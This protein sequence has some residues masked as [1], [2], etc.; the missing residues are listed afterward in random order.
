[1][2]D[3][4]F[5][6]RFI[7][8]FEKTYCKVQHD[9]YHIY[10]VDI[11]SLFAVGEIARLWRGEHAKDLPLL[12]KLANDVDKRELLILAVLLHDVGKGEGGGHADKGADLVPTNSRRMGLTKEDSERLEFLI[13]NH[14]LFAHIAQRRDLH[15]EK[16]IIQFSRQMGKSENLKMLYLLTY[17]DIKAV[18]PDVWTEWKALLLQELY[19]KSFD[20]LERGDFRYEARSERVKKVKRKVIDILGDEF[21]AELVKDELKAMTTRHLLGDNT[22]IERIVHETERGYTSY[23]ICT[24][25]V[26]GLFSRITGV[27][28]ANGMNILG[29]QIHTSTNGKVL[30]VLQVNSPQG[31]V[32]TD[33]SRWKRLEEDMRQVLEGKVRV[34]ALVE[35][36]RRPTLLSEKPKPRFPTR[37]EI[38]NE[39]SA[40]YTVIDIYSHDKVGL[41]YQITSTL[42]ELGLYIGVSKISTKV[43]QVADVFYVK[44]IIGHKI[45]RESKLKEIRERLIKAIEE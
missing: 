40:D 45:S 20:V 41:L 1:M 5:L 13:R 43:D 38:D 34:A 31:F 3:L 23:T 28:A 42:T 24:L 18:G 25:D 33:E 16:M 39:V 32:I 6:N 17:A 44:D 7:P 37:V 21:P 26:S 2:H 9:I 11:H 15:D 22:M 19:E 12:T 30:D 8:E 4:E 27:M 10:T 36:R 35:K 29:A 14:L